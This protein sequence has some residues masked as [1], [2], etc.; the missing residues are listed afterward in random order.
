MF[1]TM[2]AGI[3]ATKCRNF[4]LGVKYPEIIGGAFALSVGLSDKEFLE[5]ESR[6]KSTF[7]C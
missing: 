4:I 2:L 3:F 1:L 5:V 7:D 6:H